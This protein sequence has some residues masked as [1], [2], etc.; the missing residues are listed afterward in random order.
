MVANSSANS[1]AV[2]SLDSGADLPADVAKLN[3]LI[4]A[5]RR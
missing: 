5:Q 1:N 3:E 2:Q 4:Q